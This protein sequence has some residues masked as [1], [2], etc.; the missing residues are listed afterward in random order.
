[1]NKLPAH[2][3][4]YFWDS[5]FRAIDV[6]KNRNYIVNRLANKGDF[7]S[8][9]WL[10]HTYPHAKIAEVIS[11]SRDLSRKTANYFRLVLDIP[12][13]E[14]KCLQPEFRRQHKQSWDR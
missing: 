5:D 3:E 7:R 13:E 4:K 10:F 9:S 2:L 6:E 12:T 1:M 14:V 11:H 8:W